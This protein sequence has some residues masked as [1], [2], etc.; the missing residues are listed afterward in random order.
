MRPF[1]AIVGSAVR[2][3]AGDEAAISAVK[4][5]ARLTLKAPAI[6]AALDANLERVLRS[7]LGRAPSPEEKARVV[8]S[9]SELYARSQAVLMGP[10]ELRKQT[11][12]AADLSELDPALDA[13]LARGKGAILASPHFGCLHALVACGFRGRKVT[14]VVLYAEPSL[15]AD[16]RFGEVRAVSVGSAAAPCLAALSR[17]EVVALYA[18]AEYF[19][20]GRT[21]DFFGAPWRPPHGAARLAEAACAPM[22]PTYP[23][24]DGVRDRLLVDETLWPGAGLEALEQGLLASMQRF[25]TRYPDHWFLLRDLWDLEASERWNLSQLRLVRLM[26]FVDR[27]GWRRG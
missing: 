3:V 2:L 1:E 4:A 22:I 23:V 11:V 21:A 24:Y 25:I 26:A 5:L 8:A 17:N 14:L 16:T 19:A 12:L 7:S 18:D 13:A 15:T 10:P 27:L 20:G 9:L 6:A